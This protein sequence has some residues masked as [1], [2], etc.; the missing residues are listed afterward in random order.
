MGGSGWVVGTY[1][2]SVP[3]FVLGSVL[4]D[5]LVLQFR[6]GLLLNGLTSWKRSQFIPNNA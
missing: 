2:S 1:C 3:C 6:E 4:A 5:K